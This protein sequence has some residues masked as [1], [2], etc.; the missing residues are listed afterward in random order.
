MARST[1]AQ[2]TL[3]LVAYHQGREVEV[4]LPPEDW[5]QPEGESNVVAVRSAAIKRLAGQFGLA[6]PKPE[7]AWPAAVYYA[8]G[9]YFAFVCDDGEIA[10]LG[11]AHLGNV[12]SEISRRFL[13]TTAFRRAQDRWVLQKLHLLGQETP[14]GRLYA[15]S[16]LDVTAPMPTAGGQGDPGSARV[17]F[18]R[19]KGK[20][21]REV[22]EAD[23]RF[24]LWLRDQWKE[25]RDTRGRHLKAAVA[26]YLA[27]HPEVEAKASAQG[28][29]QH[30][31]A[32]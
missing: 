28:G 6:I 1:A 21:L 14:A 31:Q 11:E 2:G 22:A 19:H 26:A 18:G 3:R 4:S 9:P 23:P 15:E 30:A 25:P 32:G 5:Y 12:R 17:L 24:L 27:Q 13:A 10:V 16:E 7:P 8:D 29:G 20:T